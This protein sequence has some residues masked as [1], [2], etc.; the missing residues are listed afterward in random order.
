M[1]VVRLKNINKV[2]SRRRLYFYHRKTGTRLPGDPASAEFHEA[3]KAEESKAAGLNTAPLRGTLGGLMHAYKG[4]PEFQ[5]L[6]D[7]TKTDYH[8]VMNWLAKVDDVAL[9]SLDSRLVIA[10]RDKAFDKRKRRFANYVRDVL[11]ILCSWGKPRGF[12]GQN[13]AD[14]VGRIRKPR[15]APVANRPWKPVELETVLA[16][17]SGPLRAAIALGAFAALREGDAITLTWNAYDGNAIEGRTRKTG[18]PLWLP[19]P[20]RLQEVLSATERSGVQIVVGRKGPYTESG[21]R[22]SFFALLRRLKAQGLI[23]D[24]L[25]FHGLR[26][27]AATALADAGCDT[28]DIMA[29]TGHATEAMAAR[30]TEQADQKARATAAVAKLDLAHARTERG[31]GLQNIPEKAAKQ[32]KG[33]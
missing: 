27:T 22:A 16:H 24:G 19:A 31:Q 2:R 8:G 29:V 30:Y 25:T 4:S 9:T 20:K 18:E 15:D 14:G 10:L 5:R 28:R 32:T 6:A 11:S 33:L 26:H 21:F 1:V 7:R 13:P 3:W 23:E 17:A 12:I